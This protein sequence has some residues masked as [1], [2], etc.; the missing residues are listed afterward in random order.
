MFEF[1]TATLT[2]RSTDILPEH[3]KTLT[4][5]MAKLLLSV[6]DTDA[7]QCPHCKQWTLSVTA[8]Q[9]RSFDEAS[10]Q[11]KECSNP[12]CGIKSK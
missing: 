5:D 1:E 9:T 12:H 10:T 8:L 4:D 2:I 3:R 7:Y 6:S 11:I